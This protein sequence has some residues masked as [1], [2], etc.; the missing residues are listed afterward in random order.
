MTDK[1]FHTVIKRIK[2]LRKK[3]IEDLYLGGWTLTYDFYREAPDKTET[4]YSPKVI[5]G[6]WT[7]AFT[8]SC[9]PYYKTARVECYALVLKDLDDAELE[10]YFVHEL[11]HIVMSLIHTKQKSKEEELVATNLAKIL[12]D[13]HKGKNE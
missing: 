7:A 13:I 5:K 9:D 1:E 11:M 4:D 10:E 8:V 3:W 2:K 6:V 12:I